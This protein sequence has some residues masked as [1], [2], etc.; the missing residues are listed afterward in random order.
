MG[1]CGWQ[2][3]TSSINGSVEI[4]AQHNSSNVK[5]KTEIFPY[6]SSFLVSLAVELMSAAKVFR[7][8]KDN[9]IP[10]SLYPHQK[11]SFLVGY[12][13]FH[14][15]PEHFRSL[16]GLGERL[17]SA[18]MRERLWPRNRFCHMIGFTI[19][20]NDRTISLCRCLLSVINATFPWTL[21]H[22]IN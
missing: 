13:E 18:F 4:G 2:K 1:N 12:S 10:C 14:L 8:P 6:F 17:M 20:I 9:F 5:Q 11:A 21:W 16:E 15:R 19:I 7:G 3:G 22:K